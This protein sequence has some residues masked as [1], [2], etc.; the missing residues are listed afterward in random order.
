MADGVSKWEELVYTPAVFVRVANKGVTGYGTWKSV[1]N[2]EE[3][4][5]DAYEGQEKWRVTRLAE[6]NFKQSI[7]F[8]SRETST[9]RQFSQERIP[10]ELRPSLFVSAGSK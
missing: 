9:T 2:L 7:G 3:C 4:V 6:K 8:F 1:R 10:K 5:S